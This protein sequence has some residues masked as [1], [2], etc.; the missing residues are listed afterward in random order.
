MNRN[1]LPISIIKN[2]GLVFAIFSG[3]IIIGSC[4][5][6]FFT[7]APVHS[8]EEFFKG[9]SNPFSKFMLPM[10]LGQLKTGLYKVLFGLALVG[11]A[12]ILFLFAQGK[13]NFRRG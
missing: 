2:L 3:I 13:F 1:R 10:I 8:L 12:Q 5:N 9:T 7:V 4:I 11:G 6:I